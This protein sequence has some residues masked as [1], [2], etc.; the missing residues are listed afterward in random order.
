MPVVSDAN[1]LSSLAAADAL[2]LL[3]KLFRGDKILIPQAVERELQVGLTY[4]A[5]HL[6]RIFQAIA[7]GEI[8]VLQLT[9]VEQTLT[10]TLPHK[11]HAGEKE[12]II[13][14]QSHNYLFLSNDKRAM[15][16]C[17]TIGIKTINLEALLRALWVQQFCS[18][19]EVKALIQTMQSV[20]KLVMTPEQF[21][22]I[23][24]PYQR[25]KL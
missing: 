22:K 15:Q 3:V 12:S 5:T 24:A 14:C 25:K 17:Q 6:Q 4:G 1:I 19:P 7:E 16:Y 13:L 9:E 21:T 10:Q 20:E 18:Q 23:F 2:D 11:L 8:Q